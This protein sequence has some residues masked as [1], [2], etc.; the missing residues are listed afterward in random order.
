LKDKFPGLKEKLQCLSPRQ[1]RIPIIVKAELLLGAE[2]SICPD[3]TRK[4]VEQFLLPF[5]IIPFTDSAAG[6]YAQIRACLEKKGAPI[7][8]N[9]LLIAA[10]VRANNGILV[11]RNQDEFD[12]V[13]DLKTENWIME[14]P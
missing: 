6:H 2:K 4:I 3:E 1:I 8:P 11:T 10:A 14:S 13:P 12:R 5:K 7:G 9:D